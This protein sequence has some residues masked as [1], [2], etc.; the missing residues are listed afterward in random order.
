M[1]AIHP[2][3]LGGVAAVLTTIAFVP[4]VIKSWRSGSTR[5]VSLGMFVIFTTGLSLWLIYGFVIE[6][7]PIIIANIVTLGLT[8]IIIA[9]KL[10]DM[11]GR[12]PRTPAAN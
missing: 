6:S 11:F 2:D 7:R 12:T 10:R 3:L 5:D 9:F 8:G 1:D 4:Q